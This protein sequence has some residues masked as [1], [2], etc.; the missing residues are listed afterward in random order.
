MTLIS[1]YLSIFTVNL[2]DLNFLMKRQNGWKE[3]KTSEQQQKQQ[4]DV[5]HHMLFIRDSLQL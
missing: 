1:P 5:A 4:Q 2:D 3:K